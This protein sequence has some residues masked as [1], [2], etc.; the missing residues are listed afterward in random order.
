LPTRRFQI[1]ISSVAL[2]MPAQTLD[3]ILLPAL[4][5]AVLRA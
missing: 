4:M 2:Q 3:S 5:D 1:V